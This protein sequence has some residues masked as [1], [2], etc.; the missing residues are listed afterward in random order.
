MES[1]LRN[2][3]LRWFHSMPKQQFHRHMV[4]ADCRVSLKTQSLARHTVPAFVQLRHISHFC[5][6]SCTRHR[7]LLLISRFVLEKKEV[8]SYQSTYLVA[9]PCTSTTI[10][11][12]LNTTRLA[13]TKQASEVPI[14]VRPAQTLRGAR[15][16][17]R[18]NYYPPQLPRAPSGWTHIIFASECCAV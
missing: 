18:P 5:L 12:T 15:L 2:R 14:H 8:K 11:R 13:F 4:W 3:R 6:Q 16:A 10:R 7:I 9:Q 17:V 1:T